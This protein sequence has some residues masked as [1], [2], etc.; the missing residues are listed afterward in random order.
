[1][2]DAIKWVIEMGK[3]NVV[4][5]CDPM[6]TIQA[7]CRATEN[8]LEVGNLLQES[9]SLMREQPD[10]LVSFVRMQANKV[11]H[12]LARVACEVNSFVDFMSPPQLVLENTMYD[13]L[14][15]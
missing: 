6:L 8:L 14:M 15:I 4:I 2:L 7:I 3:E 12:L 5:E 13:V 10:I 9:R 11:A 1:M